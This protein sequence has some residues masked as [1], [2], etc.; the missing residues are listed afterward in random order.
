[1]R[2]HAT[3]Y[4]Y[5]HRYWY[6]GVE[7]ANTRTGIYGAGVIPASYPSGMCCGRGT[8]YPL[9]MGMP[10]DDLQ[11]VTRA[12]EFWTYCASAVLYSIIHAWT[13]RKVWLARG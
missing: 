7:G 12:L 10:R 6:S 13:P 8:S 9:P 3:L 2:V 4:L 1:M 5:E 11:L